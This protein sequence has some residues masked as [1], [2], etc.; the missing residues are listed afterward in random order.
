M[1]VSEALGFTIG[2]GMSNSATE[3]MEGKSCRMSA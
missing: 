3:A 2:Q 1:E